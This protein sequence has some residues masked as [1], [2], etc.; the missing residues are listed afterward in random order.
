MVLQGAPSTREVCHHEVK[1]SFSQKVNWN[2]PSVN[3][4]GT[5]EGRF[6]APVLRAERRQG[7]PLPSR[8]LSSGLPK[9]FDETDQRSQELDQ[10]PSQEA[11]PCDH[12][13]HDEYNEKSDRQPVSDAAKREARSRLVVQPYL[14]MSIHWLNLVGKPMTSCHQFAGQSQA[15]IN[16]KNTRRVKS[17]RALAWRR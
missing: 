16:V 2:L 11:E 15:R 17:D 4:R 14:L 8:R 7:L 9:I 5:A 13:G 12:D 3:G 1:S 10:S 6:L